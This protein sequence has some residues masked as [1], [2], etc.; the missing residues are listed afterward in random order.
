LLKTYLKFS[1]AYHPQSDGQTKHINQC[2]EMFLRCLVHSTPKHRLKWLPLA[3][4]WYNTSFQSSLNCTP[5][6]ALYG[7]DPSPGVLPSLKPAEHQDVADLLKERQWFV[8][9]LKEHLA[10]ARNRMKL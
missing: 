4:L 7:V 9:M 3:E 8:E 1:L 6:K 5:F 10:K 2:L